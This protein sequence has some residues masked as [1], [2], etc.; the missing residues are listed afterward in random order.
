MRT[1]LLLLLAILL[2]LHSAPTLAQGERLVL[3]FYYT[4]YTPD[5]FGNKTSDQPIQPYSSSDRA[6][7]ERHVTQAR[8][9]AIDALVQSWYGPNGGSANQT[10]PNFVTL[11]DVAAAQGLRAAVDVE[12][13]APFF[14][15]RDDVQSALA[16]LLATHARHPAYLKV[17]GKPVI[18]F[19]FNSR[20][21][22]EEWQAIRDAVDPN[23]QSIWI[24]EGTN[25]DYLRVFDGHHLYTIA[26]SSD[27]QTTLNLWGDRVRS[28]ASGLSGRKYWVGTAMPGWDNTRSGRPNA[29]VRNRSNGDYY[30][31]SF[32][33]AI[34]SAADWVIITSFNEWVEGTQIEPSTSYGDFY[35]NLTRDLAAAFRSSQVFIPTPTPSDT[36]TPSS[37][38]TPTYTHTPTLTNTPTPTHT[39]TPT[40]TASPTLPPTSTSTNSPTPVPDFRATL[41]AIAT[42][43]PA[44]IAF[45]TPTA[46]ATPQA[47]TSSTR[48]TNTIP[49][50]VGVIAIALAITLFSYVLAARLKR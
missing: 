42:D 9:A 50:I 25:T 45:V 10:E 40:F 22:V 41:N 37:T 26:W 49:P 3:A 18:F 20:F 43:T 13:S 27:P 5:S 14:Q 44:A 48:P 28:K 29:Y 2:A 12:T 19:W 47:A 34:T 15:T 39:H 7:I 33:G 23:R 35:I 11:L 38:P 31:D 6:T 36:P 46:T 8:A 16:S 24:A 32:N 1:R 21:S 30:R 17:D 4:W